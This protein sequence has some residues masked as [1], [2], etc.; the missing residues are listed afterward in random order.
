PFAWL[1]TSLYSPLCLLIGLG[2]AALA[3]MEFPI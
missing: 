1:D 3:I 2:F